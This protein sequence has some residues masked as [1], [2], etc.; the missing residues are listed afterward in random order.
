MRG[1][2]HALRCVGIGVVRRQERIAEA[3]PSAAGRHR[4]ALLHRGEAAADDAGRHILA[5]ILACRSRGRELTK[6]SAHSAVAGAANFKNVFMLLSEFAVAAW[7]FS[8]AIRRHGRSS[9]VALARMAVPLANPLLVGA[10]TRSYLYCFG[11][12]ELH[13][14]CAC[15]RARKKRIFSRQHEP[16]SDFVAHVVVAVSSCGRSIA[17]LPVRGEFQRRIGR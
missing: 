10:S 5:A 12:N 15:V 13:E 3:I 16:R 1:L 11:S 8:A 4:L 9:D 2:G 14:A 7:Y 17:A 6:A